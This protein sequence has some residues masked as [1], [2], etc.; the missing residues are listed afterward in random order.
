MLRSTPVRWSLLSALVIALSYGESSAA[1]GSCVPA[2]Q[3]VRPGEGATQ[4][5]QTDRLFAN[6]SREHVVLLGETHDNADHHRW[7]LQTIAGLHAVHPRL[8]LGF[9]MFPHRVQPV[10]DRWVAGELSEARFLELTDWRKTWGQEPELYL[11]IFRFARMNRVPMLALNVDRALTRRVG[12]TGWASIPPAEREGISDP[13]P[14]PA[15]YLGL[16]W[17]SY[18]QHARSG[19]PAPT[20]TP[21]LTVPGFRSFVDNMLLWDRSMA[22]GIAER[23]ARGDV[24]LVV[25][26]MGTGHLQGG[27]GVTRQLRDLGIGRSAVLLPWS[28][29]AECDEI[30]PQL[31]DALFGI[32]PGPE[33]KGERPRLGILLD[34]SQQGVRVQKVTDGS[35]AQQAGLR[36]EDIIETVAGRRAVEVG[37]VIDAVQRQAPG[38]WLPMLVRR[39]GQTVEIVAR[40][41][42]RAQQ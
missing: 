24:E 10:L 9:E 29:A 5:V 11:P 2:G 38:T 7:Q 18:L 1:P 35:I 42:P 13:S 28:P 16:L 8:V 26:L 25:A 37:D 33:D 36:A 40:F 20:D 41:P 39:D 31:A 22:Q 6:L 15:D 27:Y 12:E 21:D 23:V 4:P 32:E 14:A 3:W 17:A 30:T 19:Q 34:Q